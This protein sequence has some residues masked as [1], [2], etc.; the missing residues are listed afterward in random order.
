MSVMKQVVLNMS[1]RSVIDH[2][3]PPPS[4]TSVS[5]HTAGDGFEHTRKPAE[6]VSIL[7]TTSHRIDS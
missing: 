5:R 3:P 6:I 7:W 1:Q 4:S 2:Q